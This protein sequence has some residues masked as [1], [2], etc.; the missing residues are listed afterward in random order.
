MS[1]N[2]DPILQALEEL[3]AILDAMEEDLD[4]LRTHINQQPPVKV[5]PEPPAAK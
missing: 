5:A 2:H 1:T 3:E 4:A